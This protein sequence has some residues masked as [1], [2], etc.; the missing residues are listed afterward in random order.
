V[1]TGVQ[2]IVRASEV[3]HTTTAMSIRR[4]FYEHPSSILN[5]T[6]KNAFSNYSFKKSITDSEMGDHRSIPGSSKD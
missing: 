4:L 5:F 1:Y 3:L 2:Q 6:E